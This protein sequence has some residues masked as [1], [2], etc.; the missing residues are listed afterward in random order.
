M[1]EELKRF[2]QQLGQNIKRNIEPVIKISEKAH[3]TVSNIFESITYRDSQGREY[4]YIKGKKIY[5]NPETDKPFDSTY[6]MYNYWADKGKPF[7][8]AS[9]F[10][11]KFRQ[12]QQRAIDYMKNFEYSEDSP[13]ITLKNT[14]RPEKN[15]AWGTEIHTSLIDSIA[16]HK[17]LNMN[18]YRALALPTLESRNN[19]NRSIGGPNVRSVF[20]DH[21]Y[22]FGSWDK[23]GRDIKYSYY[24]SLG[25]A[26]RK[27]GF[28]DARFKEYLAD[29]SKFQNN[30]SIIEVNKILAKEAG[31]LDKFE[32][33]SNKALINPYEHALYLHNVNKGQ[34]YNSKESDRVQQLDAI[35]KE[36]RTYPGLVEYVN[37]EGYK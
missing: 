36:L 32:Q 30:D 12:R 17:P 24:N 13:T 11:K 7:D 21:S 25:H 28:T 10:Q 31:N 26:F 29:P 18:I 9:D 5:I 1:E 23:N 16:K 15:Y 8:L 34:K 19:N 4:R 14:N 2:F 6:Q 35:E 37:Q 3:N 20:N 33:Y 27:A 22:E